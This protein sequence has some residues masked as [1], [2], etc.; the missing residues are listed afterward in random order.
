MSDENF[1][2]AGWIAIIAGAIFPFAIIIDLMTGAAVAT[3][4]EDYSIGLSIGDFFYLAHAAFSIYVY[5][6]FK[7]LLFEYYSFKKLDII[8][9]VII[10]MYVLFFAGGFIMEMTLITVLSPTDL[11]LPLLLLT[12]YGICIFIFGILDIIF[13]VMLIKEF[14]MFGTPMKVFTILTLI[15]GLLEI[16]VILSFLT[17]FLIPIIFISWAFVFF[18]EKHEVEFV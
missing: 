13:A 16:S 18:K 2:T 1:Q 6:K 11:G 4:F 9:E 15:M 14:N 8:I 5:K 10:W 12:Y 17:I 7:H 3:G